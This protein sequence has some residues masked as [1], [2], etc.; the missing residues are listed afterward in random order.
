MLVLSLHCQLYSSPTLLIPSQ[1]Q[2]KFNVWTPIQIP[3]PKLMVEDS[4]IQLITV[5]AFRKYS[6]NSI[7]VYY[8]TV[9]T[10]GRETLLMIGWRC[11]TWMP[12][13]IFC[14]SVTWKLS[15]LKNWIVFTF[16]YIIILI[17]EIYIVSIYI[18][19]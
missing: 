9:I 18:A 13:S 11:P 8:L 15:N 7:S 17:F 6:F 4:S 3:T 19:S 2:H 1:T 12:L 14:H 16:K 5:K 10:I